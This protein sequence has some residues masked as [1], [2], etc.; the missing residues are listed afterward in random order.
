M[1]SL[2]GGGFNPRKARHISPSQP[3]QDSP[4]LPGQPKTAAVHAMQQLRM[5]SVYPMHSLRVPYAIQYA[6]RI[7]WHSGHANP[8][9]SAEQAAL[10]QTW[11]AC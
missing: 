4:R 3:G 8:R 1:N 11:S 10:H 9:T 7:P 2:N 6:Y 5:P